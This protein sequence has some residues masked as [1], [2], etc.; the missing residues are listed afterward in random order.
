MRVHTARARTRA[1]IT[2]LALILLVV[3]AAP[4]AAATTPTPDPSATTAP[5]AV[6]P[7]PQTTTPAPDSPEPSPS[8][9]PSPSATPSASPSATPAP[10]APTPS[11]P[12]APTPEPSTAPQ[13]RDTVTSEAVAAPLVRIEAHV[14]GS[15]WLGE[16][17]AP[18]TAGGA[19]GTRVEA[20]RMR[21][22]GAPAGSSISYQVAVRTQGWLAP[23]ADGATSGTTGQD[24]PVEAARIL[25][26]GPIK[27][28]HDVWYRMRV[29]GLGWMGWV[30]GNAKAGTIA[31]NL[32]VDG[33]DVRLLPK[34]AA[35]PGTTTL[36]FAQPTI[37][38]RSHVQNV[39]WQR[40]VADGAVSGTTGR[41]LRIEALSAS[42][43]NAP[44]AGSLQYNVHVQ[45]RGWMG[46][47]DA[48]TN[49]GTTGQG[50]RVE[51][52]RFRLTGEL[53][54]HFNVYY[55]AHI[56]SAG[57]LGWAANGADSGSAGWARRIEAYR[58]GL[59]PKGVA[60]PAAAG[61]A[62]IPPPKYQ[63][64]GGAKKISYTGVPTPAGTGFNLTSGR[65]GAKVKV[66]ADRFGY[67]RPTQWVDSQLMTV[68]RNWQASHG[69]PATGVVDK[70]T[71]VAMGY[72]AADWTRMDGY[73]APLK[74]KPTMTRS[75]LNE[76][77]IATALSYQGS[78]Y[79]WGASNDRVIG[80]DCVGMVMQ[81]LYSIGIDTR[82]STSVTHTTFGN[83]T[84]REIYQNPQF[85]HVPYS[86]RQR[87]DL[88]FQGNNPGDPGTVRHVQLYLGNGQVMEI[89]HIGGVARAENTTYPASMNM[90]T[91]VRP[92]P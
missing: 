92:L 77:M 72:K 17:T 82:P 68:V 70:A 1:W 50:L 4:V 65:E 2:A 73:V 6:A 81:A 5:P 71:W 44:F 10:V 39:G 87:G 29:T 88:I 35:A 83:T 27:T 32:Q 8:V 43:A 13:A 48:G 23:V 78:R 22:E 67:A 19:A 9:S 34:G 84:P 14:A 37:R 59:V 49:A 60:G 57:W 28:T 38:Y 40:A 69:L 30:K 89:V 3:P 53:A 31:S 41:G 64:P 25:L 79:V 80:A 85:V 52:V 74:A 90:P 7:A 56:S 42:V 45:N 75:Q 46:W 12:P 54:A 47:R 58:V 63:T 16:V 15:G 62:F 24:L 91:V 36:G 33:M 21:L 20:I 26:A 55:R 11:T 18:T 66:I 51:A 76:A 86:Q 61:A